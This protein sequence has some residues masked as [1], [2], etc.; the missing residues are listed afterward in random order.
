MYVSEIIRDPSKRYHVYTLDS[1]VSR[2]G[3]MFSNLFLS[4]RNFGIQTRSKRQHLVRIWSN[5]TKKNLK[6]QIISNCPFRYAMDGLW[7]RIEWCQRWSKARVR[8]ATTNSLR[9]TSTRQG[10]TRKSSSS[11]G[12]FRSQKTLI[13]LWYMYVLK[14]IL[15]K[16]HDCLFLVP[17]FN[18]KIH[19]FHQPTGYPYFTPYRTAA[20][21]RS[22]AA[23]TWPFT[24]EQNDDHPSLENDRPTSPYCLPWFRGFGI[25]LD[26]RW[27]LGIFRIPNPELPVHRI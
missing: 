17:L 20:D 19:V 6:H 23:S 3:K 15:P 9:V 5:K 7:P 2:I 10:F 11:K 25:R 26:P 21:R 22:S 4:A 13:S 1:S 12:L 27:L 24:L 16:F 18:Q 14:K 8:H